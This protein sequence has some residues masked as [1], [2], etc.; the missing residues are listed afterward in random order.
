VV[1]IFAK[2]VLFLLVLAIDLLNDV[3]ESLV[4]DR[5][6]TVCAVD[7]FVEGKHRIVWGCNDIII[8]R[9]KDTRRKLEH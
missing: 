7:E 5:Q 8:V 6:Y 1:V 4:V 3:K 9:W 2:G